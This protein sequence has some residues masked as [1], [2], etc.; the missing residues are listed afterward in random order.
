MFIEQVSQKFENVYNEIEEINELLSLLSHIEE[1]LID[2]KDI[3]DLIAYIQ[4]LKNPAADFLFFLRK[5]DK[6]TDEKAKK[7]GLFSKYT[8]SQYIN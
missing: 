6:K 2:Q 1:D 5:L 7:L 8:L 3:K 4:F